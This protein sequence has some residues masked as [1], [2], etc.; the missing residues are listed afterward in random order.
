VSGEDSQQLLDASNAEFWDELC[1]SSLARQLGV[2][3]A[4]AESLARF[5]RAYWDLYPYLAGY[6]PW[7]SGE[8][9]L[10]IG[11]GYGTVGQFFGE[12]RLDYHGLDIS[13]GPVAMMAHRL[14]LLG[15]GDAAARVKQG[16]ALDIPHPDESL[17]VVVSIGCLHHTGNLTR[18]IAEVERVVRKGGQATVMLYNSHSYR[19][20]VTMP[21]RMLREGVIR[22]RARRA[23]VERANYDA[24]AAG[25]AAPVTV[26]TSVAEAR[27]L[28][29]GWSDVRV[30]RENCNGTRF[31]DRATMLPIVGRVAG[32]DLY[33]T[34]TK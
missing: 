31:V 1:G 33:I 13:P 29:R 9:L 32:L 8:R 17:D 26:F 19:R 6:L 34:A 25:T 10:E 7:H 2:D 11:L 27:R 28:F 3:D 24:N 4:S 23:E 5:D 14:E 20:L 30:R 16:S 22:D 18:A 21:A 12:R 15:V